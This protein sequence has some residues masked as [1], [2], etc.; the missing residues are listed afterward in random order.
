MALIIKAFATMW[1]GGPP[2]IIRDK[3]SS[4]YVSLPSTYLSEAYELTIGDELKARILSV[5]MDEKE[6][7]EFRDKEITLILYPYIGLDYLFLSKKDWIEHFREYGLVGGLF[8]ITLRIEKAITKDGAEIQI[9]T[10]RDL[11]V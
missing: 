9:Y 4:F 1:A 10:K 5:S 8:Y 2:Y 3:A 6:Y 11:E 7:P